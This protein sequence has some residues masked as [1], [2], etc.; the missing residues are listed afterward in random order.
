MQQALAVMQLLLLLHIQV[1]ISIFAYIYNE[2]IESL[3]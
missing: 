2:I 3:F 1:F